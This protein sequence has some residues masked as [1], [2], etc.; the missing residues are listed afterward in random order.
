MPHFCNDYAL[1]KK[2]AHL[3]D[4]GTLDIITLRHQYGV[5]AIEVQRVM[6]HLVLKMQVWHVC[7]IY[8]GRH[9]STATLAT[10]LCWFMASVK[11][12]TNTD[13]S[14]LGVEI[15]TSLA[16]LKTE[17]YKQASSFRFSMHAVFFI[18]KNHYVPR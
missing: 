3:S 12:D 10:F 16:N 9:C 5:H 6:L 17:T 4:C 14:I 7:C 11:V 15:Y 2:M 1:V 8:F 13:S 18:R